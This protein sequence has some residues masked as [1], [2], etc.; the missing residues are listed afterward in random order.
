MI[1]TIIRVIGW[2]MLADDWKDIGRMD[3]LHHWQ[4]GLIA[5]GLS[6]LV[7]M[8]EEGKVDWRIV[9]PYLME[10]LAVLLSI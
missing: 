1:S 7:R 5:E 9:F 10:A 2:I 4:Y 6:R 3:R 8:A